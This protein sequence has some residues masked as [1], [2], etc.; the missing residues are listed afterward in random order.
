MTRLLFPF[1]NSR[2]IPLFLLLVLNFF[3]ETT[4]VLGQSVGT[5]TGDILKINSG[6]RPAAMAGV[7]TAMGDDAYAV[8]YNPAGIAKVQ[9][10]QAIFTH[11]ESLADISYEYLI[12]A[13]AAGSDGA[14]AAAF[15]YRYM[16]PIDNQ[17]G[18]PPVSSQ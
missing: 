13:T 6:A 12:F 2:L 5:A 17:N 10:S 3:A 14:F 8:E 4:P 18:N 7:Y 9:A 11:L 15:T 16:P 1:F